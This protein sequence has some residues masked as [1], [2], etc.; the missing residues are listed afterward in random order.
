MGNSLSLRRVCGE[1]GFAGAKLDDGWTVTKRLEPGWEL[2]GMSRDRNGT[3]YPAADWRC[4][5]G[6]L[7]IGLFRG[8]A[9]EANRGGAGTISEI[10]GL[11]S[12]NRVV[13]ESTIVRTTSVGDIVAGWRD[14]W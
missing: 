8:V 2:I 1:G 3:A 12:G 7:V 13:T 9:G 14:L 4:F 5:W 10:G 11:G 6:F